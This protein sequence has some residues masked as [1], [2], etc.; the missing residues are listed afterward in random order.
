L[1]EADGVG[2]QFALTGLVGRISS[3]SGYGHGLDDLEFETADLATITRASDAYLMLIGIYRTFSV[4]DAISFQENLAR[5]LS[6]L[7]AT[8]V[9]LGRGQEALDPTREATRLFRELIERELAEL[10]KGNAS[11]DLAPSGQ[12]QKLWLPSF[13]ELVLLIRRLWSLGYR[14]EAME[15]STTICNVIESNHLLGPPTH[16]QSRFFQTGMLIR[17]LRYKLRCVENRRPATACWIGEIVYFLLWEEIR[18]SVRAIPKFPLY[19][20]RLKPSYSGWAVQGCL[21]QVRKS[22]RRIRHYTKLVRRLASKTRDKDA[23]RKH[24]LAQAALI[25]ALHELADGQRKMGGAWDELACAWAMLGM[26]EQAL[27]AIEEAMNSYS[28]VPKTDRRLNQVDSE[29]SPPELVES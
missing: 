21:R 13:N 12:R 25:N 1:A 4:I 9:A 19:A 27:T 7:S 6:N 22:E 29:K 14:E 3:G 17:R 11:G 20:W 26:S 23:R 18:Y 2:E 24:I 8:L 5:S 15:S 10:Q 16:R 28:Q